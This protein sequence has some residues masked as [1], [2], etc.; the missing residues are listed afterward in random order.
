[1]FAFNSSYWSSKIFVLNYKMAIILGI[2]LVNALNLEE[3]CHLPMRFRR[4]KD[5]HETIFFQD[6]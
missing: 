4:G 2:F 6:I 3:M 1:M 5:I